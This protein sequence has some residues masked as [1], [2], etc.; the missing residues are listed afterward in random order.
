MTRHA[1]RIVLM[2]CVFVLCAR[3]AEAQPEGQPC[4]AEPTDQLVKYG[5]HIQPC[6]IGL[7]GDSDLFR[8]QGTAGEVVLIK[9]VDYAGGASNPSCFLE[10]VRPIG[11]IVSSVSAFTTCQIRTTLDV[12]GLFTVRVS[13]FGN[14]SL[15]TYSIELDRLVPPSIVARSINPSDT[16][17]GSRIDPRGD[18]DLFVFNGVGGDIISLKLTDQSGASGNP[19]CLL[20]LYRPDGTLVSSDTDV[21]SCIIDTTLNQTGVFTARVRENGDNNTM[22]YNLE[23]Q[24]LSG[25]CPS[26]NTLSVTIV[27]DGT[28]TSSPAGINC[29]ADCLERFFIGTVVTL[30]A[31]PD[32]GGAFDSWGGDP[33]CAD[34][35]VTMSAARS[36]VATFVIS[37][38][39]PTSVDDTYTTIQNNPLVVPPRGV[40]TNDTSNAGGPMTA[41]IESGPSHGVVTLDANGGFT[42]TPAAGYVGPDS[43]TYH[44]VNTNGPGNTATALITVETPPGPQPPVGLVVDSVAGQLVTVRFT[45]PVAGPA[46]TGYVLKGGL[47]PGQVL[48]SIP[49]GHTAPTFRFTAPSGSFFIRMHTVTSAGESEPSNEVRLHVGVPVAPSP[50]ENLLGLVNGSLLALAWKNTFEGGPPSNTIL[51]VTGAMTTSLSLSLAENFALPAVPGGTYTLSIRAANAGGTSAASDSVTLTFPGSCSGTPEMPENFLAYRIGTTIFVLWDPPESGPA[52]TQY[53]VRVTGSFVGSFPTTGRSV[54]GTV[55]PGTYGLSVRAT[56]PCGTSPLTPEQAVS[57]P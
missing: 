25:S 8:F 44:A 32:P 49:T 38:N 29:G 45:P 56:N 21:T 2:I 15:M 9:V 24:C 55:G 11:T 3:A 12:S 36:C 27:N 50:P 31:T 40:L 51:D 22:T 19:S 7:A 42:Y 13:E 23:Y 41:L 57:I 5:D 20:E 39:P 48:A 53:V 30:I 6:G 47:T 33:D 18:A 34:G 17:V 28:V 54:S 1:F 4:N 10:L 16:L 43:F 26:F 14:N 52:P 37:D 46:P 35:V